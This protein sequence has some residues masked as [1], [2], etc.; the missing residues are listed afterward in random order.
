M[1]TT[2]FRN[3]GTLLSGDITSPVMAAGSVVVKDGRISALG[4]NGPADIDI[5]V[6]G[7]TVAPGLWDSHVHPYFGEYSP[8]QEAF[9]TI[10]RMVR[11]GVTSAISAGSGHQPGMYLP[12]WC[13]AG[14]ASPGPSRRS[15]VL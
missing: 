13:P 2:L 4:A 15:A 5:D 9:G 11:S 12:S 7:A 3:I 1:T 8:R 10:L 14:P 6:R